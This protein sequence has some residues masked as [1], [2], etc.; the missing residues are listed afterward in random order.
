[1]LKIVTSIQ[2]LEQSTWKTPV[3]ELIMFQV[4]S[5]QRYQE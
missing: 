1:M 2:K 3:E 5:A 4:F